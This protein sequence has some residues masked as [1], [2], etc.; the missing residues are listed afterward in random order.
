VR[1][2]ILKMG[3][4]RWP[5]YVAPHNR[6]EILYGDYNDV[7]TDVCHWLPPCRGGSTMR[8]IAGGRDNKG[9]RVAGC[10]SVDAIA[11]RPLRTTPLER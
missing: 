7:F 8:A 4:W 11:Y 1:L 9:L 6:V 3:L 2:G 5:R 10:I